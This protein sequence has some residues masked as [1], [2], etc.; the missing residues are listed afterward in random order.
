[1]FKKHSVQMKYVKDPKADHAVKP[2]TQFTDIIPL[3]REVVRDVAAGATV[4]TVAYVGADT[5]R[6]IVV[7][8]VATKVN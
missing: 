1:M 4:L 3:A 7:H 2:S 8:I 5:F 6:R